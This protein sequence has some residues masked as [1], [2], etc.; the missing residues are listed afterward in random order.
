MLMTS[1]FLAVFFWMRF[2]NLLRTRLATDYVDLLLIHFPGTN[3][4]VQ[5]PGANRRRREETWRV[6]E[7]A[8]A[9]GRAK[10]IGVAN[11]TRRHLKLG[12]FVLFL[13]LLWVF[14]VCFI[15]CVFFL[16]MY[17]FG[18]WRKDVLKREPHLCKPT[19]GMCGN[20]ELSS[21]LNSAPLEALDRGK[22]SWRHV[23]SSQRSY[24]PKCIHISSKKSCW[25]SVRRRR[26]RSRRFRL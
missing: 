23:G 2:A 14:L 5:S 21:Q 20:V 16:W 12:A 22:N 4:A 1:P 3:D 8:K 9:L 24:K 25:S 26:Y 19:R 18:L 13:G 7:D 11:F 15:L 6:L 17:F 10:A